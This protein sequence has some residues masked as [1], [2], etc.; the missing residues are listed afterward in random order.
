MGAPVG[1]NRRGAYRCKGGDG[2]G[3][4]RPK[5]RKKV[6][7]GA[8]MRESQ[9]WLRGFACGVVE[10]DITGKRGDEVHRIGWDDM[11]GAVAKWA[12]CTG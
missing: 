6:A 12:A 7:H 5:T 1:R 9:N 3:G 2:G 4:F 8:P 10:H 11:V